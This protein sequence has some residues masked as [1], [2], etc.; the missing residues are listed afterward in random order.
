[1]EMTTE[2]Q[3]DRDRLAEEAVG[4][5]R[6]GTPPADVKARHPRGFVQSTVLKIIGEHPQGIAIAI[7]KELDRQDIDQ[8]AIA[9]ALVAVLRGKQLSLREC[10]GKYIP[11][12]AEVPAGPDQPRS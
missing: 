2:N 5:G 8:H 12:A 9:A 4:Q 1:M 10:G 11:T 3:R 7:I 6:G